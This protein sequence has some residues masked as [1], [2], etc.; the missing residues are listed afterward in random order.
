MSRVDRFA[1]LL[2]LLTVIITAWIS[3]VTFDRI[4][5]LE[6]E[7][8]YVWQARAIAGGHLI[9]PSPPQPSR[10]LVPFVVDYH[11]QRF[12]KYPPAWPVVLAFGELVGARWLVNSLL[13][14]LGVW[15]TYRLGKKVLNEKVG[16]LAALLTLTSPFFMMNS[17]SLLS[18]AWSLVLS[19]IF[20]LAWLDSFDAR[21]TLHP[22]RPSET[23]PRW[24][25]SLVAS[26]SLGLLSL[27]RPLTAVGVALPFAIH[28][29]VLL[30]RGSR[31]VRLRVLF[32][33]G[34]AGL[35]S[36]LLFLWQ[37]AASGD[38]LLNLY[39]LWWPYDRIGFGPGVGVTQAGHNL[40]IAVW[41]IEFSLFAGKS[42]L[43]GWGTLSWIF[44]PFGLWAIRRSRTTLLV[45]S[46]IASLLAVYMLYW[47]GSWVYGPRYY[48]EGLFSLTILSAAGILFVAGFPLAP[49]KDWK[50]LNAI[51]KIR[52]IT[53]A[54]LICSLISA[55]LLYYMP[56]RLATLKGYNQVD[57]SYL[58]PF[59][60]PQARQLTP[61]L[62]FVHTDQDWIKYGRLLE[63][64]NPYLDTPFIFAISGSPE[65][66]QAVI[67]A[68]PGRKV[69]YYHPEEPYV[70]YITN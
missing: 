1:I 26:L 45:S 25:T 6:D 46:V 40:T 33:G 39:T 9:L 12:G 7:M 35:M 65:Q 11:G 68:Y 50:H 14:G 22:T 67:Q 52:P 20:A 63:L 8:A 3:Q 16:L 19:L 57:S 2:S 32:I 29:L 56:L 48:Y 59:F 41:N 61:A 37:Y 42:D 23:L 36:A 5:H 30:L 18:H 27:T 4:P 43:F 38:P 21:G 24:L 13:A 53:I 66:N 34:V 62:V 64:E 69:I 17:A 51:Q 54:V 60:T 55:N 58:A 70:F 49:G 15:L 10:F 44:L 47:I 28:G 31:Q